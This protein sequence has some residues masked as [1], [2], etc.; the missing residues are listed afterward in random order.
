M[1]VILVYIFPRDLLQI[2]LWASLLSLN[3]CTSLPNHKQWKSG[4]VDAL[5]DPYTWM[6]LGAAALV[7]T[8]GKDKKISQ[9]AIQET[10]LFGSNN[11]SDK[12]SDD[13]RDVTSLIKNVSALMV[14]SECDIYTHPA[15]RMLLQQSIVMGSDGIAGEIKDL[16]KRQ[17]P[18]WDGY[19]FPSQHANKA[20]SYHAITRE[21]LRC[22]QYVQYNNLLLW[23]SGIAATG[24]AY[25][26]V[27]AGAH[28]PVDVLAG[29]GFGNF[30][31]MTVNNALR[32]KK[33]NDEQIKIILLPVEDGLAIVFKKSF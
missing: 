29:A 28:Y 19:T 8:S 24:T 15:Q 30:I 14:K 3:A 17:R 9:K 16:T 26:R 33:N 11:A 32:A 20:F 12:A 27:E 31:T 1:R 23:T 22:S 25:A 13:L 5:K 7:A 18:I 10:P 6:P 2:L 21:N 4:T